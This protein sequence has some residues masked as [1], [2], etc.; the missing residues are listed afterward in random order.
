VCIYFSLRQVFKQVGSPECSLT[1]AQ[2]IRKRRMS[3]ALTDAQMIRK[4]RMSQSGAF[5]I[6][7]GS[8]KESMLSDFFLGL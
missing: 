6:F 2:M 3:Q 8:Q 4:R 1:D 7:H 5:W